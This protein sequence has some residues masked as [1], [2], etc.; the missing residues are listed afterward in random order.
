MLTIAYIGNGKSA[1]R[2]HLPFVLTRAES[3]RVKSIYSRSSPVW[4]RLEG[5]EYVDDISR[6]WDDPEVDLVVVC[7]H[8]DSHAQFAREALARG[9]HVLVEKPFTQTPEEARELFAL[10][11]RRG[12]LLQCYQN[13]RF[14][15]D[16]LT[17]QKV[18]ASGVL[19][20]LL[21]V[22]MHYDYYRPEVPTHQVPEF[23]VGWSFLYGHGVHTVDQVLSWFGP[24]DEVRYDVRQLLGPGRMNDYFDLDLFYGRVKVS[25]R[26]SYFRV[27]DRP[28]FVVYG[29]RGMFVKA[30]RDRQEEHLK[31][32]YLPG[33]PGFG[34][35][36][37]EHYG[38]LT[39]YDDEGTFREEKVVSEVGDYAR[40]Y[41]GVHD[42]I[43]NGAP[44]IVRD[45]QTIELI[46]ILHDG[47]APIVARELL[48]GRARA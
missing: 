13:R 30:T 21:E 44:K 17:T 15:S 39:Y 25:V 36:L 41:D 9:K 46:Q 5:V 1:N 32:F 22:E 43:V 8:T 35:D 48:E 29:T 19:G 37:P 34:V 45:E 10:A 7:T 2:Y 28:S 16:F 11:E 47:L 6:V 40:I 12:L 42:S 38:T 3:F 26:S 18:V 23:S 33:Q 20:D 24:P 31:V 4:P 27:K 14:D